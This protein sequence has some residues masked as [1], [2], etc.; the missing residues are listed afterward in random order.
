MNKIILLLSGVIFLLVTSKAQSSKIKY[1]LLIE[2]ANK[3]FR[4]NEYYNS[5]EIF[6]KAFQVLDDKGT[7]EDRYNAA[8]AWALAGE[9]D[10]SFAQLHK[11]TKIG[12]YRSLSQ[13]QLDYRLSILH[14]DNR[15]DE[16]I[17][18]VK[19]N[20]RVYERELGLK[21]EI[22]K[23]LDTMY[24]LDQVYRQQFEEANRRHGNASKEIESLRRKIKENDSINAN[25][26]ERIVE[27]HGSLPGLKVIGEEGCL[28]LFL[29]LQHA[30]VK[31]QM[32]Y[33]PFIKWIY[34]AE[35]FPGPYLAFLE[36][37]TLI[38]KGK[39]QLYGTQVGYNDETNSYYLLPTEELEKVDSR[40]AKMNLG[41]LNTYLKQNYNITAFYE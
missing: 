19:S 39:S 9:I 32:R 25:Y 8:C 31:N 38:N 37:C 27:T 35:D 23:I 11:I 16:I 7:T 1:N 24:H 10:S 13:I 34:E 22:V 40:R 15:W 18:N 29:V 28:A 5:G 41:K 21:L 6:N 30:S 12:K 17:L 33:L 3:S 4:N 2:E 20:R 26:L 36:D 14:N